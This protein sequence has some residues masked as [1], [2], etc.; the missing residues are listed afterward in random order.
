[1][2]IGIRVN[3]VARLFRHLSHNG[4]MKRYLT[5]NIEKDLPHK[6]VLL[7]GPR[8]SGKTTLAKQ[9]RNNYDYFNYDLAEDRHAL[10]KKTLE[11]RKTAYHLR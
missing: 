10:Q 3:E 9:F 7:S 11:S 4:L 6:I 2:D 1:M 5:E 8:Q